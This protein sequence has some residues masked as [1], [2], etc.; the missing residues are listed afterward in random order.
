MADM[1]RNR[2]Q[3]TGI[4]GLPGLF[5][6]Y[7]VGSTPATTAEATEAAARVRACWEHIKGSIPATVS[8]VYSGACDVLDPATGTLTGGL[9]GTLPVTTVGTQTALELPLGTMGLL[10]HNTSSIIAGRRVKGRSFMGPFTEA[11]NGSD[12]RPSPTQQVDIAAAGA[13]LGTT[14][15]TPIAHVVWHRPKSGSGGASVAVVGYSASG[16]W[17]FL[18]SRRP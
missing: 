15:T 5:T 1:I 17:S 13:L 10:Q 3:I 14:I 16:L 2:A 8:I 9:T 7:F 12:G 6:A 11:E 18:R 4:E